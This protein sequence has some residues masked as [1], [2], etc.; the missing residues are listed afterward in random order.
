M[1][2]SYPIGVFDSGVGGLSVLRDIRKELW[3]EDLLYVADS[4]H[5]PYGDKSA[6]FVEARSIAIAQFLV[7]Q[8][9]KAM[10]VACNTATSAAVAELRTRFS[11]PIVAMEPAVKP[12]VEKTQSGVVGVL[13][14]RRTV[15]SENFLNL[16]E[17][18]GAGVD[19][20]VQPCPGLVEQVEVGDFSGNKTRSLIKQYIFP[21]LERGADTIVLG[22]TH[23][24]FL[25]SLIQAMAGP[26][27]AII[28]PGE[29][30]ARELRRRL[31]QASLLSCEERLGMEWFWSS[32][33]PDNAQALISHL[34][35]AEVDVRLLPEQY[36]K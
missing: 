10:V 20:I 24:P 6:E 28:D 21:L 17:R 12:A 22:C 29:A 3:N 13:A 1:Q 35:Q 32:D 14:T 30:I 11:I 8:Q 25:H 34:W 18:F 23:Y 27:V 9:V 31:E 7:N 33:S 4:F 5:A 16:L 26:G 2:N 19:I 15:S 36:R